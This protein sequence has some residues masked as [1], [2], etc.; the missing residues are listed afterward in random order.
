MSANT[1]APRRR[2]YDCM[3]RLA[4]G[5]RWGHLSGQDSRIV[6]DALI[7]GNGI[8]EPVFGP[9]A[10]GSIVQFEPVNQSIIWRRPEPAKPTI[11][12]MCAMAM[13]DIRAMIDDRCAVHREAI[14]AN[15][16]WAIDRMHQ[17]HDNMLASHELSRTLHGVLW[18]L[19]VSR[20]TDIR[21][22]FSDADLGVFPR[23]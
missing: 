8:G 13:H 7:T 1:K 4:D 9:I 11:D 2:T 22:L 3:D 15:S 16:N 19:V 6:D 23:A 17:R 18:D 12:E 5:D 20:P 21:E 14:R 10:P